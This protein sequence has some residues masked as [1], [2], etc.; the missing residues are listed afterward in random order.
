[1]LSIIKSMSIIGIDGY[2]VDVEVDISNGL[3]SFDIVG[4]GDT[5]I[6]ESRDRVKA[7]IKNSGF[8][9]PM[10]KITVNLAPANTKKEGTSFDL[11]IAIG[12][13]TCTEQVKSPNESMAFLGELSLNGAVR[14][15]KG[16]LPMAISAK[17]NLISSMVVPYE[18]T[19]E[20]AVTK[21]ISIYPANTLKDVVNFIN[22][23]KSIH[24]VKIKIEEY[25]KTIKYD[26]DFCDV[27]GQENVKRAF[28]IAAAG[29]HN[30]LM[31]GPP[32][33]GKT[34]LAR[35]FPTILPEM[36][37]QESLE[38][39]K[40]HSIAGTL[41]KNVPLITNR[42]FRAP[43]HTISTIALIGGGRYPKPGEVS[44]A[45]YGVLFLDELPEF[46]KDA[47]EVLRQPLE[48]E[49]VTISRVNA[50]FTYPSKFILIAAMN[51]CPCGYYGDDTH[52]CK[53][54]PNEIRRYQGKISGPLLD[55]IDLHIEVNRVSK[56][57][58]FDDN[59]KVETS[60]EI[61][62]RVKLAREIQL[63]RY[64]K[65]KIIFNS[66]LNNN[67]IRKYCK[68]EEKT[69]DMLMNFFDKLSLSARAY[70]KILKISRTIADLEGSTD[71]KYEHVVEAL[72]YR[73][74][75]NKY[76]SIS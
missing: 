36:T 4:L 9:F 51:P 71:I 26:I 5:E 8:Q 34:M 67:M 25:F 63:K 21:D 40:I 35:R 1:M 13:L 76:I 60:E 74:L 22:G 58:Y 69:K 73:S 16:I 12:I 42:V 14:P 50:T 2:V 39:T 23:I 33:S 11:P 45:H 31:I 66:Q 72:Q 52:I 43:H 19:F 53:C 10:G 32:G 56:E 62:N 57:K 6:K 55:R 46:R 38:V 24:P 61:R 37:F 15:I 59:A 3:P 7:S 29:G 64:D 30:I 54:T 48:D 27:K 75:S 20:A 28:E 68:I 70:N 17:D 49:F 47:L 44:L 18:N 41:P 65:T